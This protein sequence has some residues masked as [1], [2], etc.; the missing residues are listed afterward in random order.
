VAVRSKPYQTLAQKAA[1][2]Q[3]YMPLGSQSGKAE[4][5]LEYYIQGML[6][7]QEK[8]LN[9]RPFLCYHPTSMQAEQ[10]IYVQ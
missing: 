2:S 7:L 1:A 4:A 3:K 8:C 9:S 10:A 5:R 6:R